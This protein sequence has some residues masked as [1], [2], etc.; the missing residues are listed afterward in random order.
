M[1]GN[2]QAFTLIELLVVVLIIGILAAVAVPQYQKAVWKSRFATIKHIAKTIAAAEEVYYLATG[3]YTDR[4]QNLD[5]EIPTP[6]RT[7]EVESYG[8]YYYKWGECGLEVFKDVVASVSCSLYQTGVT[9]D[10]H[11][12]VLGYFIHLNHSNRTPG[13]TVCYAYGSNKKGIP[14]QIC[15]NETNHSEADVSWSS[16]NIYGWNY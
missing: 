14:Y 15:K 3:S 16:S 2:K 4:I 13:K 9:D 12:R 11:D 6:E 7:S 1:Q 8:T 10:V 5:I